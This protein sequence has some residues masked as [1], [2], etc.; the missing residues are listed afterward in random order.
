MLFVLAVLPLT[1]CYFIIVLS[2]LLVGIAIVL[3]VVMV[4]AGKQ[5]VYNSSHDVT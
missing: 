2:I 4:L 5:Y 3:P 1:T